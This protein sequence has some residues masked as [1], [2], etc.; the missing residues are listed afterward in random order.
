MRL[1]GVI[2][3]VIGILAL[4]LGIVGFILIFALKDNLETGGAWLYSAEWYGE[5]WKNIFSSELN[6]LIEDFFESIGDLSGKE[7]GL[8]SV[9]LV[10]INYVR[11]FLGGIIVT[12]LGY[13]FKKAGSK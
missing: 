7:I 1:I 5:A 13:V 9:F 12:F 2:L 10:M 6:Q 11:L 8:V 3:K 4:I